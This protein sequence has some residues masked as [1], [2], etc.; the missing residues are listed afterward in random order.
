MPRSAT[1]PFRPYP[2]RPRNPITGT[3]TPEAEFTPP[4]RRVSDPGQVKAMVRR[5]PVFEV[6]A[7]GIEG[8]Q[9]LIRHKPE[10]AAV[11]E[12]DHRAVTN[13]GKACRSDDHGRREYGP[14]N[15]SAK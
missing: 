6:G 15:Y 8:P 7:S 4:A 14:S 13:L 3:C 2:H 1:Y 11:L 9:I 5:D 12:F 10:D